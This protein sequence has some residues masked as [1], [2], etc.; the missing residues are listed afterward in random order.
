MLI[1]RHKS[2]SFLFSNL[3][4]FIFQYSNPMNPLTHYDYTAEEIIDALGTVDMFV[5]GAGTGG[6]VTGIG[7]KLKEKLPNCIIITVDPEGSI[8]Y[9]EGEPKLYYVSEKSFLQL[10]NKIFKH[11][12][13]VFRKIDGRCYS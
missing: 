6:T 3:F 9:G 7:R 12:R 13:T 5:M 8:I 2:K 1:N 11:F 10:P 4:W